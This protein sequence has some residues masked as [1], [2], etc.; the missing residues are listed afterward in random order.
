[1]EDDPC[2]VD[3]RLQTA[4]ETQLKLSY[5]EIQKPLEANHIHTRTNCILKNAIEA[6]AE[7]IRNGKVEGKNFKSLEEA[8][9]QKYLNN[10]AYL[11][12]VMKSRNGGGNVISEEWFSKTAPILFVSSNISDEDK[13]FYIGKLIFNNVIS[14]PAPA[15]AKKK[16]GFFGGNKKTKKSKKS[17]KSKKRKTKRVKSLFF[18]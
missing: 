14:A 10:L 1:M 17:K 7:K 16:W 11:I 15:P 5:T 12:S 8:V 18:Y 6:F 4:I 9:R 13:Q 3:E 2:Y